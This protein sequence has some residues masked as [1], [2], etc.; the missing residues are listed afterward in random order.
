M[1][2]P[3]LSP[4]PPFRPPEQTMKDRVAKLTSELAG[5]LTCNE[6]VT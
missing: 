3:F 4:P 2:C 1:L 5:A 6:L